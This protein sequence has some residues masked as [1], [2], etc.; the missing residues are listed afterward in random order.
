MKKESNKKKRPTMAG[1]NKKKWHK[2]YSLRLSECK[3]RTK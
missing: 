3:A 2:K 1:S